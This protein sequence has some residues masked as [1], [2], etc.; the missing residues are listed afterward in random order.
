M[1]ASLFLRL[2][3]NGIFY[4]MTVTRTIDK[5][6]VMNAVGLYSKALENFNPDDWLSNL[7]N[8]ALKDDKGNVTLFEDMDGVPGSVMG[9]YF[10][11]SR[12]TEAVKAS[13]RF[14][15]KLFSEDYKVDTVFGLTPKNHKGALWLNKQLGFTEL[16]SVDFNDELFVFVRLT[17]QDWIDKL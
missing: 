2:T 14:L 3:L 4:N 11:F 1:T 9:H 12:G 15:R 6:A 5:P 10:Y 7:D 16:G 17:K 8:I 13:K